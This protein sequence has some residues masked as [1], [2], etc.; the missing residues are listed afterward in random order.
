MFDKLDVSTIQQNLNTQF[1]GQ[2]IYIFQTLE[3]TNSELRKLIHQDTPVGTVLM[4]E[5]QTGGRGRRKRKWI[6]PKGSSLLFSVFLEPEIAVEQGHVLTL[7]MTLAVVNLVRHLAHINLDI[8]WPNDVYCKDAKLCGV[9]TEGFL[10][11][12]LLSKV[13]IGCGLNV[14]QNGDELNLAGRQTTS[15]DV[16]TK[17]TSNRSVIAAL[18]FNELEKIYCQFQ[19]NGTGF[20]VQLWMQNCSMIGRH[21]CIRLKDKVV[22]GEMMG[23]D[24]YGHLKLKDSNNKIHVFRDGEVVEVDHATLY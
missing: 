16:L 14:H 6:A 3:S 17:K 9:L 10:R 5:Y 1:I 12:G 20:I 23:I 7:L 21:I 2:Q 18:L 24:T 13:I 22:E 4:A 19:E 8:I 15:L 11:G